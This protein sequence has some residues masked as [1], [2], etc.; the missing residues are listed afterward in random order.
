LRLPSLR[1]TDRAERASIIAVAL[2]VLGVAAGVWAIA[3]RHTGSPVGSVRPPG[4]TEGVTAGA[5]PTA[6]APRPGPAAPHSELPLIRGPVQDPRTGRDYCQ[7]VHLLTRYAR[8]AYGLDG[9]GRVVG[10]AQFDRRL[11]VLAGTFRVLSRQAVGVNG[12]AGTAPAWT[13]L[14]V[15]TDQAEARLRAVGLEVQSQPMIVA[16]AELSRTTRATLPAATMGLQ[17][18]CGVSP[19]QVGATG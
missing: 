11:L 16:L 6:G 10:G 17:R 14:A 3:A 8:T 9:H 4:A 7:T 1:P 13:R 15:A 18:T 2:L 12:V 19:A 5:T